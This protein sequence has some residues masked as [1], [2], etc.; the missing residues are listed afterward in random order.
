MKWIIITAKHHDGFAM[1]KSAHPFN[2]VDATPFARD[3]MKELAVA[4][5]ARPGS[6]SVSTIRTTRTGPRRAATTAPSKT[7]T[8]RPPPSISTSAKNV[9]GR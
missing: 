9:S 4:T 2:I 3:P 6:A 8:A 1:F 7:P 5:A